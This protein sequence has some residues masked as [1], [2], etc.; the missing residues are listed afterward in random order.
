MQSIINKFDALMD[1]FNLEDSEMVLE[2]K[3]DL[4]ETL[5]ELEEDSDFLQALQGHG[6]DN[7]PGYCDAYAEFYSEEDEEEN[8][9]IMETSCHENASDSPAVKPQPMCSK[10]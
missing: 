8:S 9:P 4:I 7:W 6:V 1:H 3:K 5:S 2:F 10:E